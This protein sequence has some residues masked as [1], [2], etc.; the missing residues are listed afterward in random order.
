M[1]EDTLLDMVSHMK[2]NVALVHQMPFTS[3]REGFAANFEKVN[4]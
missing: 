4:L 2:D 1:R 3:D